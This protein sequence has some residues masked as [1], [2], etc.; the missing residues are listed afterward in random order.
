MFTSLKQK[1]KEGGRSLCEKVL[2]WGGVLVIWT[3]ICP[4]FQAPI[5][6]MI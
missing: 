4:T 5:G 3:A 1:I 6:R 2:N